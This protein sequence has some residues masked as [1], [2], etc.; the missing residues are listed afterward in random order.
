MH[1]RRKFML[2]IDYL[3]NNLWLGR[4]WALWGNLLLLFCS[5]FMMSICLL[6][7]CS[8]PQ[9]SAVLNLGQRNF[10]SQRTTASVK[11]RKLVKKLKI[12]VAECS[13]P[14]WNMYII[15]CQQDSGYMIKR[16][17]ELGVGRSAVKCCPPD[18]TWP[19]HS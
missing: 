15:P 19:L 8:Y 9:T 3:V 4:P 18:V 13:F 5:L 2:G 16:I 12:S 10:F 6:N 14:K 11:T 17:R 1:H 7:I